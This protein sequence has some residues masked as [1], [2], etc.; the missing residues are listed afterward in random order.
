MI[1][2]LPSPDDKMQEESSEDTE[3]KTGK[4]NER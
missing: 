1:N 4:K 3:K 2:F